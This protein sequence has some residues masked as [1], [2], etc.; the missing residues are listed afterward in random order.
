[1]SLKNHVQ[2][3]FQFPGNNLVEPSEN[4]KKIDCFSQ[5]DTVNPHSMENADIIY[6]KR[7]EKSLK[8]ESKCNIR[9]SMA[10][11]SGFFTSPGV[12]DPEELFGTLNFWDMEKGVIP[13]LREQPSESLQQ[14]ITS[15]ISEC[16]IRRS[17]AWDKAFFTSAGMLYVLKNR[18]LDPEELSLVNKGFQKYEIQQSHGIKEE[19]WRSAESNPTVDISDF[20][21]ANLE[22]DLFDDIRASLPSN[23]ETL[24][25]RVGRA[26]GMQNIHDI[27][28]LLA[29]R[30]PKII[31]R[32]SPLATAPTRRAYLGPNHVKIDSKAPKTAYGQQIT[33]SKKSCAG[34]SCSII[35]TSRRSPKSSSSGLCSV[36]NVS[37]GCDCS[38]SDSTCRFCPNSLRRTSDS[39]FT[40]SASHFATP[41]RKLAKTN[42]ELVNPSRST[43]LLSPKS[44]RK[45]P[46]RSI[47]G[48]LSES[49]TCMKQISFNSAASLDLTPS[50]VVSLDSKDSQA[51]DSEDEFGSQERGLPNKKINNIQMGTSPL[52]DN[53]LTNI[54]ASGLRMPFPTIGFFDAE[55]TSALSPNACLK[56]NYGVQ[57]SSKIGSGISKSK[58]A[59]NR[60]RNGKLQSSEISVKS[61]NMKLGSQQTGVLCSPLAKKRSLKKRENVNKHCAENGRHVLHE[62]DKENMFGLK[63][64]V[65]CLSMHIEAIDLS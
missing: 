60:T 13:E 2:E 8:S 63:N 39:R 38:Q 55:N 59:A 30:L 44:S 50:R 45:S 52:H 16:S 11:D 43:H 61:R 27:N 3:E 53:S 6:R 9:K 14:E 4:R 15:R 29:P 64:Q 12:L 21:L 7:E 22:I 54:K 56:F 40:A 17:L 47:D 42:I 28:L 34:D 58:G 36:T 26:T 35:P 25:F 1:M 48:W 41:L 10:W 49:S 46:A 23:V 65:N 51:S 31:G 5:R 19:F 24:N 20:S 57:S 62:H 32:V 18:V 33:L 37:A